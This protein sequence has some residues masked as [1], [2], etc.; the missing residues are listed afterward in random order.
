[1]TS[2]DKR[3]F[4]TL[5]HAG[6]RMLDRLQH[7]DDNTLLQLHF[8]VTEAAIQ[9]LGEVFVTPLERRDLLDIHLSLLHLSR[10][11]CPISAQLLDAAQQTVKLLYELPKP[12]RAL[13][14]CR[15]IYRL[16]WKMQA[17]NEKQNTVLQ[18]LL[19]VCENIMRAASE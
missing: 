16:L 15:K 6:E 19:H 4:D 17:V 3:I 8:T 7:P 10:V 11:A 1:M 2:S 12:K 5:Q 9:D 18:S 14:S 13:L